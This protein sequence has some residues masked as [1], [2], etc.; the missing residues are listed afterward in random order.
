MIFR[1]VVKSEHVG[2]SRYT[3][4]IDKSIRLTLECGHDVT[5]KASSYEGIGKHIPEKAR[6]RDCE[7]LERGGTI[8]RGGVPD[9]FEAITR[10]V[11]EQ[12]KAHD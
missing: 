4:Y 10:R 12:E 2:A 6:C 11:G 9:D 1:K 5:N 3:G 8:I 7:T